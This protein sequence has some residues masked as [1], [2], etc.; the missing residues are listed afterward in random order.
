M[1]NYRYRTSL[2][3]TEKALI[4]VIL[5]ERGLRFAK[6]GEKTKL[7]PITLTR[8]SKEDRGRIYNVEVPETEDVKEVTELSTLSTREKELIEGK[9]IKLGM[10]LAVENETGRPL[11]MILDKVENKYYLKVVQV[12]PT[13]TG[14]RIVYSGS[15]PRPEPKAPPK[16]NIARMPGRK[17]Y[18]L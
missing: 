5:A 2:T 16:I 18:A 17:S 6:L 3:K 11:R 13:N 1:V 14:E 12:A 9:L 10:R 7:I 15:S 8:G 4:S